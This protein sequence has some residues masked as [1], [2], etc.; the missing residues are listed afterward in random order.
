MSPVL[1]RGP[2]EL[3][4]VTA[5]SSIFVFAEAADK[6]GSEGLLTSGLRPQSMTPEASDLRLVDSLS[7][8]GHFSG[9]MHRVSAPKPEHPRKQKLR[10]RAAVRTRCQHGLKFPPTSC[11]LIYYF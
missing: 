1:V 9:R 4:T 7:V 8:L 5:F 2:S 3:E 6:V 11:P 10:K